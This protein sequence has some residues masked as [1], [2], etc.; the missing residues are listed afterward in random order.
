MG[1]K[2]DGMSF[3]MWKEVRMAFDAG[4]ADLQQR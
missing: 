2:G 4:E 1:S 3:Q